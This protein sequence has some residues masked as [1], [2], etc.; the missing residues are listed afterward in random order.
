MI[1]N[2]ILELL[3]YQLMMIGMFQDL[4]LQVFLIHHAFL[5]KNMME[6]IILLVCNWHYMLQGLE[7]I[8]IFQDLYNLFFQVLMP[9]AI[10]Y[11]LLR[12]KEC[13]KS[14]LM[15]RNFFLQ[16]M[17]HVNLNQNPILAEHF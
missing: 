1:Q 16:L 17:L 7:Y 4:V 5:L 12:E 11:L 8:S 9:Y 6:A 3:F 13:Y 14:A 2:H 10:C 15:V